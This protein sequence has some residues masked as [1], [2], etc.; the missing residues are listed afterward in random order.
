MSQKFAKIYDENEWQ[1]GSGVGSLPLNNIEYLEFLQLFIKSN[2]I[3]TVVDYGC[4]DWQSSRFLDWGE[5]AY[6]GLDV[7][8]SVVRRNR[9]LFARGKISFE[10]VAPGKGIPRV[11]L[12]VCKDVFQHLP[13]EMIAE[14]ILQFKR[15]ARFV[16]ITNDEWPEEERTNEDIQEGGWRPVRLDRQPFGEVAPVVLSWT[17]RW[18]GWNP[19]RKATCLIVGRRDDD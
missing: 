11:D 6:L 10:M 9:E 14:C 16:L 15:N 4:G 19:T 1:Y 12:V 17:V 5:V 8:E 7:V 2:E 3:Q 13:N 18:G